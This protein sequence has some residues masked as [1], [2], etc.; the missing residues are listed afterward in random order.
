MG[1]QMDSGRHA[2]GVGTQDTSVKLLRKK[3]E[4]SSRKGN[5]HST[6]AAPFSIVPQVTRVFLS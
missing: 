2:D 6:A 5:E 4:A 1:V 3:G